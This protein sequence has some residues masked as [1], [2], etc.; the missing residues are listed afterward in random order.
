MD[1]DAGGE[2]NVLY[3]GDDKSLNWHC[4][5]TTFDSEE[6]DRAIRY[7]TIPCTASPDKSKPRLTSLFPPNHTMCI[8]SSSQCVY[9]ELEMS[10]TRAV[11]AHEMRLESEWASKCERQLINGLCD[12][13]R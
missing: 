3:T 1:D 6:G 10:G 8:S 9:S 2:K 12:K 11:T 5:G 4:V 7:S 13:K